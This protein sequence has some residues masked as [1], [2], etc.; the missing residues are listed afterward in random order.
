MPLTEE[1]GSGL[2]LVK[3]LREVA[4]HN[5]ILSLLKFSFNAADSERAF[6][7]RFDE[8]RKALP[9][10]L[11]DIGIDSLGIRLTC[12]IAAWGKAHLIIISPW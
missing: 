11:H 2:N 12:G 9:L 8:G 6:L 10:L 4:I 7:D 1:N 3:S 5:K